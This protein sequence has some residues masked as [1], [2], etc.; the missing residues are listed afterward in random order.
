MTRHARGEA[1]ECQCG[2][3]FYATL[4]DAQ[5]AR[6]RIGLQAG[7]QEPVKYYECRYSGWH[8]TRKGIPEVLTQPKETG[9]A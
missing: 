7:Y 2:K 4:S 8:W 9:N 6:W 1:R 5:N 3:N